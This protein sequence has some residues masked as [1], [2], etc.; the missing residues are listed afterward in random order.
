M[1]FLSNTHG[2]EGWAG[3]MARRIRAFD[4][5]ATDLGPLDHWPGSLVS[6]VQM[7]L[8]SPMPMVM[9]CRR[10]ARFKPI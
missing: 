8:A 6:A 7:M 3:E 5:S 2:C 1:Q 9:Q 10:L 4:W